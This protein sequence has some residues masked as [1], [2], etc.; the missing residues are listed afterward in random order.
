MLSIYKL[1]ASVENTPILDNFTLEIKPGSVHALMGPNGSGKSTLAHVLAGH[2]AY[3]VIGGKVTFN[4]KDLLE[5]A[6]EERAQAGLF[7]AFQYPAAIPGVAVSHFLRL[8]LQ[9]QQK[10]RSEALI[11]VAPFIRLLREQMKV[12]AMPLSF[13]E[14]SVNDGFSGGEK[15]RLEMLQMLVLKPK[16][17]ILDEID[18][19]LDIDAM[20]VVASAVHALQEAQPET[21]FLVITHYQRLLDYI[22]PDF[23]HIVKEGKVIKSGGANLA[24]ELEKDGYVNVTL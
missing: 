8:A 24:L 7:L 15:K 2:P 17:V 23:V 10:A 6:A 5:M 11:A 22:T 3:E 1:S 21:S 14:R 16:L 18:S 12:L 19:G 4:G 9:A 20:K 13:A